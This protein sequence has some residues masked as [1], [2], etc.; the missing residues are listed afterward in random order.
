MPRQSFETLRRRSQPGVLESAAF[1]QVWQT[2]TCAS[3]TAGACPFLGTYG[4]ISR[5]AFR[6]PNVAAI[7][8]ADLAHLP[9]PRD[10]DDDLRLEAFNVL[11]HPDFNPPSGATTGS[12]AASSGSAAALTSST[13]GQVASTF[14]QARVFQGSI[15]I[16]F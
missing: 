16:N 12:L 3:A 8:R 15:K 9:D 4:N 10:L 6:G 13:F 1:P 11:N 5:N 14:N 2:A 7:R